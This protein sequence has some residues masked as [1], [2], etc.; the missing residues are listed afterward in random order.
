[1]RG[2]VGVVDRRDVCTVEFLSSASARLEEYDKCDIRFLTIGFRNLPSFL[3]NTF[4]LPGFSQSAGWH[5]SGC[6]IQYCQLR[7]LFR[8]RRQYT[9]LVRSANPKIYKLEISVA[10]AATIVRNLWVLSFH[11]LWIPSHRNISGTPYSTLTRQ[12]KCM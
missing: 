8:I 10:L 2:S 6:I 3:N 5:L 7:T 11:H 12:P 4:T 9:P 1:M